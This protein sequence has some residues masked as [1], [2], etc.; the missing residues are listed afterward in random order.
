M[1]HRMQRQGVE[2]GR[3]HQDHLSVRE[4]HGQ[5]QIRDLKSIDESGG[6]FASK[7]HHWNFNAEILEDW[8]CRMCSFNLVSMRQT[9]VTLGIVVLRLASL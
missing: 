3:G 6:D 9:V 7:L 5:H 2:I 1:L 8:S 4:Y